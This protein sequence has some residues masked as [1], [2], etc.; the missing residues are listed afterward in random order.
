MIWD[1]KNNLSIKLTVRVFTPIRL[2]CGILI[3]NALQTLILFA[4]LIRKKSTQHHKP[5]TEDH[6]WTV[7][8]HT[9]VTGI[10]LA[11]SQVINN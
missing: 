8:N 2:V 4:N 3:L 6:L 5:T 1:Q 7:K 10:Q 9:V 11:V